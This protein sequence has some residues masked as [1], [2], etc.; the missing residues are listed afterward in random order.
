VNDGYLIIG[1][2]AGGCAA[3]TTIAMRGIPVR[4]YGR[5]AEKSR[6][7]REAGGITLVE[8]GDRTTVGSVEFTDE[9]DGPLKP[10][11]KVVIMV[12]TS[13]IR[14]Y[15]ATLAPYLTPASQVLLTPGHTGG[16]LAFRSVLHDLRPDLTDLVIGET[17]TL[18]FVTRMTGSAEVTIWRRLENLLTG[19]LPAASSA[20]L[21]GC[22]A[23]AFSG[24]TPAASVLESSLS[25]L[26]AVLHPAGMIAN[27]GWIEATG[28]DFRFYIDGITPGVARIMDRVDAERLSIAAAFDLSLP[29]FQDLFHAAGMVTEHVWAQHDTY[30][31]VHNGTPNNKIM[32]PATMRDRYV[33][34]DVGAGLVAIRA[35]GRCASVAT[36]TIDAL[37]ELAGAVNG[38]D[39]ATSGLTAGKLGIDGLDRAGLLAAL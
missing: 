6:R 35:L 13:A 31:A 38:T 17:C 39:Y 10:G 3:A 15:A 20:S 28:G 7:F 32:A 24:L 25:N 36:P 19:T 34:E 30:T 9:L 2:G 16:A 27:V 12:P 5:S 14:H 4:L 11:A 23:S 33:E 37:I 26:N 18:P 8:D 21:V 22:F 1:N 29:T